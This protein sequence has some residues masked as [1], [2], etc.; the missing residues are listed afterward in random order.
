MKTP[1]IS[2][3]ASSR[4]GFAMVT[5][6]LVV[7]VLSVLAVGAAWLATSEKKTAS[8]EATH[9][10]SVFSADA[11]GEAAINF[12]RTSNTP[13]QILDFGT[14]AVRSQATTA[15]EGSQQYNYD[16]N[17]NRR[18]PKPGWGPEYQDFDYRIAALGQASRTGESGVQV[19]V[20]RLF[21]VGY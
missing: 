11:G 17:F 15:L 2:R 20:S 18:A 5:A 14:M 12:V 13:P 21:K 6:L 16:V 9:L 4:D 3:T 19:V 10:R 8:A 1:D 7:L